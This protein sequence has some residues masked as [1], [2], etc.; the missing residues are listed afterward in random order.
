MEANEYGKIISKNLKRICYERQK[1]NAYN[2]IGE[3][4]K[5]HAAEDTWDY[6]DAV[7]W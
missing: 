2:C 4:L 6:I 7:D 5:R 3:V 1:Q